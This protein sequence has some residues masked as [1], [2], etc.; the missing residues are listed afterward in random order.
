MGPGSGII[1]DDAFLDGDG[2]D[3]GGDREERMIP[4][5]CRH[6]LT[7][8]YRI[9]IWTTTA[10]TVI[11]FISLPSLVFAPSLSLLHLRARIPH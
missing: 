11:I 1:R 10:D 4:V 5:G 9:S 3:G 8:P 7:L 6:L 2:D